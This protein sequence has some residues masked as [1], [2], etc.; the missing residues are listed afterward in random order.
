[1]E[2]IRNRTVSL[3]VCAIVAAFAMALALSLSVLAPKAYAGGGE[4]LAN[5]YKGTHKISYLSGKG[6]D[7]T[8]CYVSD[9]YKKISNVKSSNK[10][11]ATVSV[12]KVKP[13]KAGG[14][15]MPGYYMLNVKLKKAG[16]TKIS[17][18]YNGKKYSST[19]KVS[20][21][22]N[23]IKSIKIGSKEY[24]SAFVAKKLVRGM[25]E[26]DVTLNTKK[27]SGKLAVKAAS[28]WK[29]HKIYKYFGS[30]KLKNGSKVEDSVYV[31]MKN[32]KTG[33]IERF[34]IHQKFF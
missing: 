29:I 1:M 3:A 14:Y 17:F 30:K 4:P 24:K 31:E 26:Y 28:G 7:N 25:E 32:K 22:S 23:P 33:L 5:L 27:L 11:V 10:K 19:L 34:Y 18:T 15:S 8:R 20:K 21:Y 16:T 9:A 2:T 12:T 13:S 6:L